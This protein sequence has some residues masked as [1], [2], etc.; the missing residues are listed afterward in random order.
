MTPPADFSR[1]LAA[2]DLSDSSLPALRYARVFASR[3]GAKLTVM[4]SDPVIYPVDVLGH[5]SSLF[6][7]PGEED[8]G[9]LR[10]KVEEHASLAVCAL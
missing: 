2:T 1:I 10:K 9:R 6:I 3:F 7:T 8:Q 5:T 4:Y